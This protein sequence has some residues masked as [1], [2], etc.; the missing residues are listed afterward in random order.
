MAFY[1]FVV[2][3]DRDIPLPEHL[4]IIGEGVDTFNAEVPD[5]TP[6]LEKLEGLGVEVLQVNKLDGLEPIE[7][8][9][10]EAPSLPQSF[11]VKSLKN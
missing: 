9:L 8:S 7:P 4:M 10:T 5:L 1:S 2:R 11:T 6:F 3:S